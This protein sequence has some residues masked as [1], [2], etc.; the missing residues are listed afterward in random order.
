MKRDLAGTVRRAVEEAASMLLP[1]RGAARWRAEGPGA[2]LARL[3]ERDTMR[4]EFMVAALTAD[5]RQRVALPAAYLCEG[6]MRKGVA[7]L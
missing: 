4:R 3:E 1:M 2:A 7:V 5:V 6:I